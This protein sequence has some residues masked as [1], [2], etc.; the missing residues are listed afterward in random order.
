MKPSDLR[1]RRVA[2]LGLGIDVEAA[3]P[4]I[5]AAEPSELFTLEER[6]DAGAQFTAFADLPDIDIAVRSPGF[7]LYRADVQQRVAR[8]MRTVTPLGL[9][10]SE[11]GARRTV[12]IT[13]TKGK[14]TTALLTATALGRLD[15]DA[16]VLGNI[17]I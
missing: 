17:G 5:V 3:I 10:L 6:S 7:P 12:A 8:G 4:A 2:L 15:I 11:R 1:G 13:G 16:Q 9:W 14:S